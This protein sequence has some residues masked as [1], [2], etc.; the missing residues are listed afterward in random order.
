MSAFGDFSLLIE[1]SF[2]RCLI[3]PPKGS[4]TEAQVGVRRQS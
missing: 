1:D 3:V 4:F 2:A